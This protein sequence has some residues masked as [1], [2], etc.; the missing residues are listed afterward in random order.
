STRNPPIPRRASRGCRSDRGAA[1]AE[2]PPWIPTP[3]LGGGGLEQDRRR[4]LGWAPAP[5]EI[6]RVVQVDLHVRREPRSRVEVVPSP[7][8][9]VE[10][11]GEALGGLLHA[12]LC[13]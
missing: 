8:E 11:P 9:R 5:H 12:A 2:L 7:A 6:D 13:E 4:E 1:T 10:S 3:R